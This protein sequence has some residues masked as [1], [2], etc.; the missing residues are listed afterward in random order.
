MYLGNLLL[1]YLL[2][3]HLRLFVAL[4]LGARIEVGQ[5]RIGSS[6]GQDGR[7][8][9]A[10]AGADAR[11]RTRRGRAATT[12]VLGVWRTTAELVARA[13]LRRLRRR[14]DRSETHVAGSKLTRR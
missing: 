3:P 8:A 11:R 14:R 6:M 2:E 12:S 5:V 10:A 7:A 9:A 13:R 1:V 4:V